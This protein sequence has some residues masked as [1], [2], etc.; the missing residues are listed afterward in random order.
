[1]HLTV[2]QAQEGIE[3]SKVTEYSWIDTKDLVHWALARSKAKGT[4]YYWP[5]RLNS[6]WIK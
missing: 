2:V 3:D 1:M 5:I 6:D 4:E